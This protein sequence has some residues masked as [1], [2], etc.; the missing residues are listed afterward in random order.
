M[1]SS[2]SSGLS[3]FSQFRE[4]PVEL[5]TQIWQ[6]AL[7]DATAGRTIRVAVHHSLLATFHSCLTVGGRFCGKCRSCDRYRA[8]A[9][10]GFHS[11]YSMVDGYFF[12]DR[13]FPDPVSHC[14]L[15]T[16][17]LACRSSREVVLSQYGK[18]LRIHPNGRGPGGSSRM[19]RYNPSTDL[20]LITSLEGR[21]GCYNYP[22][23]N[24]R[25][26]QPYRSEPFTRDLRLFPRFRDAL[27]SFRH[28]AF[29]Y[30]G[31]QDSPGVHRRELI[32]APDF[33]FLLFFLESMRHL[34]VWPDPSLWPE[35][36]EDG[37]LLQ[38][39]RKYWH[40]YWR[41]DFMPIPHVVD[42]ATDLLSDYGRYAQVQRDH[43]APCDGEWVPRPKPI[44]PMGCYAAKSWVP[45][46]TGNGN[47]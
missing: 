41:N 11:Q 8:D 25:W 16:L 12:I 26:I 10:E 5:R 7:D 32:N 18:V 3:P 2:P 44:E 31:P 43:F 40:Q 19:V 13:D 46:S 20:L 27:S 28:V 38:D 21:S 42:E 4:L 9:G 17:S 15:Q 6:H 22:H 33:R 35:A 36:H 23:D 34:Y 30:S 1:T 37:V 14:A 29:L 45:E 39:I 47:Q 24:Q